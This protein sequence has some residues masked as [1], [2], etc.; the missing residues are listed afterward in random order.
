M[1]PNNKK[2]CAAAA[3]G[4]IFLTG[5]FSGHARSNGVEM[6]ASPTVSTKVVKDNGGY[7]LVFSL[8]N[9]TKAVVS[10][11]AFYF[12]E[13]MLRLRATAADNVEL[14][15]VIPLISPG[16]AN[17]VLAPGKTYVHKVNLDASFPELQQAVKNG[18][19]HISWELTI[20]GEN[21]CYMQKVDA[22]MNIGRSN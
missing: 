22:S 20:R 17:V 6:C 5:C 1:Q 14:R 2:S 18:D 15:Q 11:E 10:M 16:V 12:G 7:E 8:E 3:L 4:M 19:V 13:N 9:N 21:S